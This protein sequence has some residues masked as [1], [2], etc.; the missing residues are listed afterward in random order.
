MTV[1]PSSAL[2][3]TRTSTLA[4]FALTASAIFPL[5]GA[6][7]SGSGLGFGFGGIGGIRAISSAKSGRSFS[8]SSL[9]I[10]CMASFF[11]D[12]ALRAI[13]WT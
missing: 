10:I 12:Y 6:L 2:A 7:I 3:L 11:L 1:V 9:V 5:I 8:I 13:C 4:G